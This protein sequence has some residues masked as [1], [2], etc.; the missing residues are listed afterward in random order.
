MQFLG[1]RVTVP[2]EHSRGRRSGG[3]PASSCAIW[4][5]RNCGRMERDGLRVGERRLERHFPGGCVEGV[6]RSGAAAGRG[7]HAYG[8]LN[9][10][11]N[12]P[13]A[14]IKAA[15]GGWRGS[16][17][18]MSRRSRTRPRYSGASR[19]PGDVLGD[20]GKRARYDAGRGWRPRCGRI[21]HWAPIGRLWAFRRPQNAAAPLRCG[22][23]MA[24]GVEKLG[25]FV[26]ICPAWEDIMGRM[27][28]C[29]SV[30]GRWTP[31]CSRRL[32]CY[33]YDSGQRDDYVPEQRQFAGH[34]ARSCRDGR[35]F[36]R[37]QLPVVVTI[38]VMLDGEMAM[39]AVKGA[40]GNGKFFRWRTGKAPLG[41]VREEDKR[42][43]QWATVNCQRWTGWT[44]RRRVVGGCQGRIDGAGERGDDLAAN[45]KD[46]RLELARRC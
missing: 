19:L 36:Q 9:V 35:G 41:A 34:P 46:I 40:G 29:W 11:A 5:G 18:R 32:G 17:T 3:A 31:R 30:R 44:G 16:G 24:R 33:E 15:I 21:R 12:A 13:P 27:A 39:P 42:N 28:R 23:V 38:T 25:R 8:V 1:E 22:Y 45:C 10:P 2:G 20:E 37:L 7:R 26:A 6:V 14:D 43:S 4:A